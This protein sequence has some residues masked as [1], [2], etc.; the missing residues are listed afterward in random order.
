MMKNFISFA[1]LAKSSRGLILAFLMFVFSSGALL[2][3][4]PFQARTQEPLKCVDRQC[5]ID[6]VDTYCKALVAHDP[7]LIPFAANARFV[8]NIDNKPL[9]EGLWQTA[10]ATPST[11]KIYVPDP[12]VGEVGFMGMM[13]EQG[14]PIMI[15]LRLKVVEG[16][17]LEAEHLVV[18]SLDPRNMKYLQTVRP[19]I[20]TVIP[21]KERMKRYEMAG[22]AYSYY[23]ALIMDNGYLSP[24]AD[25][26]TRRENGS[27]A[28]N[29]GIPDNETEE[30][31]N[32]SALKT[33]AQLNT[34]MMD[35]ID[36]IDNVR[37]FA[38][39][40]V[41]GLAIGFSHFRHGMAKREFPIYNMPGVTSRQVQLPP[42]DLP[43]AHVYKISKGEIHEIEALGFLTGY[44]APSGW[45]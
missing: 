12:A 42:F 40:P 13:E 9:G 7:S 21:E 14:K 44:M 39:D 2:A 36:D 15:A 34:N 41:T 10:S 38:I 17:V 43:A 19:G 32:Y 8:E 24:M 37:V 16:F 26:C 35:Y 18:R 4:F 5:L 33:V 27:P 6:L 28:S 45:E 29:S 23:D 11:F 1:G 20:L 30:S 22:I 25:D 3:Q 31:P